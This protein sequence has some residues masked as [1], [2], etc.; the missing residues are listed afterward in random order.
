ML[1]TTRIIFIFR[2]RD[3][4]LNLHLPLLYSGK[5]DNPCYGITIYNMS[6]IR[7]LIPSPPRKQ[8]GFKK[9]K[10]NISTKKT[11]LVCCLFKDLNRPCR[12]YEQANFLLA[13]SIS[14]RS[15]R[16][17]HRRSNGILEGHAYSVPRR[18]P[19]ETAICLVQISFLP[20][21]R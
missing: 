10:S 18:T 17:E 16:L 21:Y 13:A 7:T 3:P 9:I 15:G 14:P 8:P 11:C 12:Y 19:Q 4:E 5:G 20:V 1:V 6:K 2:F